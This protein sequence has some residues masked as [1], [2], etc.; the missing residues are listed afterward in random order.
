[1]NAE[2]FLAETKDTQSSSFLPFAFEFVSQPSKYFAG[3]VTFS[4]QKIY[5]CIERFKVKLL[6]WQQADSLAAELYYDANLF[7]QKDIE[8]LAAQFQAF[9]SS[10]INNP[11]TSIAQLEILSPQELQ[12]LSPYQCIHHWI[13]AQANSTPNN[14][15]VVF[16]NQHLTYQELNAKANNLANH[17]ASLGVQPE[18]VVALCIERSLDMIVGILGIL[19]AGGAYVP[20]DPAYPSDRLTFMLSDAGVSVLLTQKH[21]QDV[22]PQT[23]APIVCLDQDWEAIAQHSNDT[24][25]STAQPENLAYVIYTSGSTGQP[26][27]VMIP[28]RA[29][30]NHMLWMQTEFP[31]TPKDRVLQKTPFSFDASVWEFY[32]PLLA[33]GQ[34]IWTSR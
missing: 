5:S 19:K 23:S 25:N 20:L 14:I 8:R 7:E 3:D 10:A 33:G 22:L 6:C 2:E 30:C 24:P 9:L 13:E 21:L 34:L 12:Q 15:A 1:M 26:K 16:D 4:I 28:H 31:I 18:T 29:L 17:L 11:E 27:G 32:A